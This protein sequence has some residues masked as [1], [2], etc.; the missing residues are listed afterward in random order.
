MKVQAL[1]CVLL[2]TCSAYAGP[3]HY[4]NQIA[5]LTL[6]GADSQDDLQ[7][8]NL[9]AGD[10]ITPENIRAAIQALYGT[11][12]Y[13]T[14]EVDADPAPG[15]GTSLT[16]RVRPHYFF[17]TFR[18]VPAGLLE[19]SLSSYTRLPIGEKFS[20]STVA[21]IAEEA[22][23]LLKSEGYFEANIVALPEFDQATRLV[24]VTFNVESGPKSKVGEIRIQGGEQT[25]PPEDLLDE[26]DFESGD[27]FSATRLEG[28]V[29]S[30]REQFTELG[31]L[32]TRVVANQA[33]SSTT[34]AV[35]LSVA[36]EPGQFTLVETRGYDI[37][38]DDL[39]ELVPVF[40][41]GTVDSDLV[42]EG[43]VGIDRYL[44]EEGYFE[45]VVTSE[46]IEAPLDNAIQINYTIVPGVRH[47]IQDIR[48]T[49]NTVFT[50][51]EIRER[52]R[53]REGRLFDRGAFSP[54]LL[55]EDVRTVEA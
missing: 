8:T 46:V 25:F 11:G 34:Q 33:Y 2:L 42:E 40:E 12:R 24:S 44:R 50:T 32:N 18:M 27:D 31:F 43:R 6:S 20:E 26:F 4:G 21:R 22:T 39:R 29:S 51:D 5:S 13:S 17:S 45:A 16:F 52:V 7:L 48:I 30:I 1:I 9:R 37:P 47:T 36:V 41:E 15:G 38:A 53:V 19:R 35:D 49:G 14:I 23:E 54:D 55:N 3:Q 10:S 28:G